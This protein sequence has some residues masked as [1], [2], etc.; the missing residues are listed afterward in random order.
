MMSESD[1]NADTVTATTSS[2][3]ELPVS[4]TEGKCRVSTVTGT[5]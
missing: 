2:H 1:S 3:D 5:C 4:S